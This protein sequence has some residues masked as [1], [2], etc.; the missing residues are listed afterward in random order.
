MCPKI[1]EKPKRV[2]K[3]VL[4]SVKLVIKHIWYDLVGDIFGSGN[5][6]KCFHI[7]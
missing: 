4:R 1:S 2:P 3:G 5:T 7:S 6:K